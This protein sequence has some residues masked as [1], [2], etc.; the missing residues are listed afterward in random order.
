MTAGRLLHTIEGNLP[1]SC[2]AFSPSEFVIASSSDSTLKV[3]DLQ[4]FECISEYQKPY[5]NSDLISFYPDGDELLSVTKDSL[6]IMSWDPLE[7]LHKIPMN[8][9]TVADFRILP[10]SDKFVAAC[11]NGNFVDVWGIRLP[12]VIFIETRHHIQSSRLSNQN[13]FSWNLFISRMKLF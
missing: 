3:H 4:T 13:L 10:D 9:N 7:Q 11:I 2:L 8:W 12:S 6:S 1:V 5:G